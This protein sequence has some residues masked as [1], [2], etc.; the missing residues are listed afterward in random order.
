MPVWISCEDSVIVLGPTR[1]G[2]GLHVVVDMILDAPGAVVTTSTRPDNLAITHNAR[3]RLGPVAVFDPQHLAPG[4]PGGLRWSPVRGCADPQTAMIRARGLA[5]DTGFRGG[6]ENGSYWQAQTEA[7][8]RGLLHAA[9]L[10]HRTARDLYRWSLDPVHASEAVRLMY[11][12]DVAAAGWADALEA[13]I[14]MDERTRSNVWSGV[15]Q[16]LGALADPRVLDAV[17]P[18]AHEQFDPEE[19]IV[20]GGTL[21]MLGTSTGAGAANA[22]VNAFVEDVLET[23]RRLAAGNPGARLDPPLSLV[24][25]EIGNLVPIPSLPALM[26]EGGGS[27]LA[28]TAVLQSLAQARGRWGEHDAATIW[29]AATVK[30]ILGGASNPKDLQDISALI[31]ER[32]DETLSTSRAQDGARSTSTSLRRVPI[33]DTGRLRT[34]PFGTGV[35]MLR[36][37]PPIVLE[38]AP[39][40]DR[41]DAEQLRHE[42]DETERRLAGADHV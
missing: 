13:T 35:L 37:A 30:L 7:V 26:A 11:N 23:A 19:F 29:D 17:T 32:D 21:Y 39:W 25:D 12:T 16:A 10:D 24:L 3:A 31:G 36:S 34:L 20:S 15:R 22:L 8:L 41:H 18:T 1:S 27:G 4:I 6:V 42:R 40:T 5:S 2:K 14:S 9:A 33:M 28:T 38:M